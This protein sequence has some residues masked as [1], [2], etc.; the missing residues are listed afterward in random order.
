MPP[1]TFWWFDGGNVPP[2]EVT[3][4]IEALLDKVSTSGCLLI[5][6]KGELFSPEDGD[7]DFRF[8]VRMKE[9]KELK[10]ATEHD[11]AKCIAE[12][13]PRNAFKGSPDQRQ[14]LEWIAACKGGKPAYSDFDIAAYITEIILL[15]CVAL[16]VGKKL[17]WDG[18][19]MKAKNAPEAGQY[20]KREYR[21][22]WSL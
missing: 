21:K 6:D 14:H 11:A 2:K 15:G 3:G 8:F 7:Q 5:G 12:T 4:P 16:R 18:P 13:L 19:K 22:G 10:R 17:E 1:L 9:E 20:V